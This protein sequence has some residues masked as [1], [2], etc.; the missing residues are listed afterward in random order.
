MSS[1]RI[2]R[3]DENLEPNNNSF[4]SPELKKPIEK[5]PRLPPPS[6][7]FLG[8]FSLQDYAASSPLSPR[9]ILSSLQVKIPSSSR[10][11][12]A[13]SKSVFFPEFHV[14][15]ELQ[16]SFRSN[17]NQPK[18]PGKMGFYIKGKSPFPCPEECQ[19]HW[20]FLS[21]WKIVP[22]TIALGMNHGCIIS[23]Q[24]Q[25]YSFGKNVFADSLCAHTDNMNL[26]KINSL[27]YR[28]LQVACG[29]AFTAFLSDENQIYIHGTF[30]VSSLVYVKFLILL[31]DPK[32]Y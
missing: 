14:L 28:I 27:N 21:N 25:V 8:L 11:L 1:L 4:T 30:I 29:N 20:F 5:S 19:D 12:F 3:D 15:L 13:K 23:D 10:N 9:K 7:P 31:M 17:I 16:T 6:S 32:N 22:K 2:I 24:E 18:K 26:M